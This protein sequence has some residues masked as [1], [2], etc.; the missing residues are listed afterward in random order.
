MVE[1]NIHAMVVDETLVGYYLQQ[2]DAMLGG[3]HVVV[4]RHGV[5]D[6]HG[7]VGRPEGHLVETRFVEEGGNHTD[8]AVSQF[9]KHFE[10]VNLGDLV[11][12]A[13]HPVVVNIHSVV[14]GK[15]HVLV[16]SDEETCLF[17]AESIDRGQGTFLVEV[18][19]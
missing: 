3:R 7:V 8:G 1:E 14:Q 4:G 9:A 2:V 19:S 5:V 15:G 12:V 13:Y 10:G 11:I 17:V 16:E 6:R 18:A